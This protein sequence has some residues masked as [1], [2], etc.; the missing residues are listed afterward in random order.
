MTRGS[1][2]RFFGTAPSARTKSS[3]YQGRYLRVLSAMPLPT[4]SAR[5]TS[6]FTLSNKA[7]SAAARWLANRENQ[8][9]MIGGV[10]FSAHDRS[11]AS[12]LLDLSTRSQQIK[13]SL[14]WATTSLTH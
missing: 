14:K 8:A 5:G 13:D 4:P 7:S 3:T 9:D 1:A 12:V 6:V 11:T 2:R 10:D